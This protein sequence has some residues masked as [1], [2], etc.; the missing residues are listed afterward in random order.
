[1]FSIQEQIKRL[2]VAKNVTAYQLSKDTGINEG[3]LSRFFNGKVDLSLKK[4]LQITD[5][6][7]C[8]LSIEPRK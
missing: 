5:Y 8:Y 3:Q 6:L 2:M 4:I 1:M 7:D